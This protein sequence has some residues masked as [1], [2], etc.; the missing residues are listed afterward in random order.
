M[1]SSLNRLSK[2]TGFRLTL[3]FST[4]FI[5][6]ALVL[7]VLVYFLLANSIR[8]NNRQLA[9]NKI[10]QYTRVSQ[11]RGLSALVRELLLEHAANQQTGF[12][13]RVSDVQN[14]TLLLTLPE[15]WED[16]DP[17]RMAVKTLNDQSEWIVYS[18]KEGRD[19]LEV[20]TLLL[21]NDIRLEVGFGSE[22]QRK[23]LVHFKRIF[24]LVMIPVLLLGVAGGYVF[25]HRTLR[26]VRDLIAA[27]R[28]TDA[29]D[30]SA[31]VPS[32]HSGDELDELVKLF[33]SMLGRIET[34]I[35]GMRAALDNVAHDLRTPLARMRGSVEAA[36]AS[37]AGTG[38][39][40]CADADCLRE[41]LKDCA[42]ECEQI[43]TMLN[44]LMD[45]SEAESG[46]MTLRPEPVDFAILLEGV[47][48]LYRFLAEDKDISIGFKSSLSLP[49]TVDA[50]RMRQ[51]CANLLDNAVK[52]T[53]PG[54]HVE[55]T[56]QRRGDCVEISVHDDG[57]G[58]DAQDMPFIFDRLYRGDKSRSERGLGLGLS[59]VR[60]V[61]A[62]HGGHIAVHSEPGQGA[63]FTI[64]L[65]VE[66]KGG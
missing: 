62:A 59:L 5:F 7:Y 18:K 42:E 19:A 14:R 32:D 35:R 58:V 38:A 33:N 47:I 52:Y 21:D 60:A 51:V 20:T 46:V 63:R 13:V 29:G 3:W 6:F 8:E 37:D 44:Q 65:P 36:L 34:L 25:A 49:A 10:G 1:F 43:V 45:I 24:A 54:G 61:V 4:L 50:G 9:L 12:F 41:T 53:P 55:V 57:I 2:S 15:G 28:T 48:E 64:T 23:L 66:V 26:P 17:T 40:T 30:M 31:R 56:A 11:T 27:I 39:Q 22:E 16:I